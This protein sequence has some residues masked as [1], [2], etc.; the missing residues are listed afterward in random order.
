MSILF[1]EEEFAKVKEL[2]IIFE[3]AQRVLVEKLNI[4]HEDYKF[5]KQYDLIEQITGRIKTPESIAEKLSRLKLPIT[6][7]SARNHLTDI[8]GI[9]VICP[10]THDISALVDII[11]AM[12]E[13]QGHVRIIRDYVKNP[14]PSG[15]RSCHVIVEIPVFHGGVVEKV[16]VEIQIRTEAMNLWASLEY[17]ARYKYK[18]DIPVHMGDKLTACAKKIDELEAQMLELHRLVK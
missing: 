10:F 3:W 5:F 9:R 1:C 7:Q 4:I 8:A 17:K 6:A 12:P 16:P 11:C 14:K 2:R 13:N 15:Y 18:G